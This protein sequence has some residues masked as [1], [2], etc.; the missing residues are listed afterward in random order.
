M[1]DLAGP[2]GTLI[3]GVVSDR[4][5]NSRRMPICAL[6]LFFLAVFMIA[7]PYIP[8]SRF[9]MGAGMFVMG[10]LIFIP[11]SLISGAAAIDFG[12]QKGA[13]TASGLING[14]G[15]IGQTIGAMLPGM[16]KAYLGSGHDYWTP[17][18]VG[19]GISLLIAGAMLTPM[20]NRVPKHS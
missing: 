15:S 13:S 3:G 20:W 1:F 4:M 18:F 11:D 10:F 9:G 6:A 7:F 19:L 17:I 2:A 5:F 14:F 12:T 8:V 16:V